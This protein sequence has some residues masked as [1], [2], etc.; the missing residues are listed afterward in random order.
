MVVSGIWTLYH[1]LGSNWDIWKTSTLDIFVSPSRKAF[2]GEIFFDK[3]SSCTLRFQFSGSLHRREIRWWLAGLEF[4]GS[5]DERGVR[6]HSGQ[7]Y[8]IGWSPVRDGF[9]GDIPCCSCVKAYRE[10]QKHIASG[11]SDRHLAH[12]GMLQSHRLY[13]RC[14][15]PMWSLH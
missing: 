13:A 1:Q 4:R 7:I 12:V 8:C 6:I 11:L 9:F 14:I 3:Q 15:G 5:I 10:G 2:I